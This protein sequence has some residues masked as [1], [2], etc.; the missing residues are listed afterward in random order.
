MPVKSENAGGNQVAAPTYTVKVGN[1]DQTIGAPQNVTPS[2]TAPVTANVPVTITNNG[3]YTESY[4]L[5]G[6]TTV[7]GGNVTYYLDTNG[8]GQPD[9]DPITTVGPLAPGEVANVIAVVTVPANTP[10]D[11][12]DLTSTVTGTTSGAQETD[13]L[14]DAVNVGIVAPP[15]RVRLTLMIPTTPATP[16]SPWK[17]GFPL[18]PKWLLVAPS[19]TP[20]R[21]P[22]ATT[23]A[24]TTWCSATPWAATPRSLTTL[25]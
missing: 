16:S 6:S 17:S 23:P 9:G 1:P 8:D 2:A 15:R 13:T 10:V 19:P 24:L 12:Y 4:D 21:R 25:T 18:M 20:L 14:T 11:S 5:A 22:T 3:G 7:P